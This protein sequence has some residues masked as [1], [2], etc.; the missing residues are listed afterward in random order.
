[1]TFADTSMKD[2]LQILEYSSV[3]AAGSTAPPNDF[4]MVASI[5]GCELTLSFDLYPADN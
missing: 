5:D 4:G 3:V 1:M 2:A